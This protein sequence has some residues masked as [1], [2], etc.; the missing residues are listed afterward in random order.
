M[1][2]YKK[3]HTYFTIK[4]QCSPE[5]KKEEKY[6]LELKPFAV[7]PRVLFDKVKIGTSKTCTLFLF[8]PLLVQQLVCIEKFPFEKGFNIP[9]VKFCVPPLEEISINITWTPEKSINC[10]ENVLFKTSAGTR[11]QVFFLGTAHTPKKKKCWDKRA[12]QKSPRLH[13]NTSMNKNMPASFIF[14]EKKENLNLLDWKTEDLSVVNTPRFFPAKQSCLGQI[15]ELCDSPVRRQTYTINSMLRASQIG[16][17]IKNLP[18][19]L[20][21]N[22][23]KYD[24]IFKENI[25]ESR[26]TFV[27]SDLALHKELDSG[28][29]TLTE[30]EVKS[31]NRK[32]FSMADVKPTLLKK[33]SSDQFNQS[34]GYNKLTKHKLVFKENPESG[35][36]KTISISDIKS[37][38]QNELNADQ[39]NPSEM[40]QSPIQDENVFNEKLIKSNE[41]LKT[42]NF[43]EANPSLSRRLNIIQTERQQEIFNDSLE[44]TTSDYCA[45][46][47]H[48]LENCT[49]KSTALNFNMISY[50]CNVE[51][52]DKHNFPLSISYSN[53][54]SASV[55]QGRKRLNCTD[56][57][58]FT[59]FKRPCPPVAFEVSNADLP[60]PRET[61]FNLPHCLSNQNR[62]T[63]SKNVIK[64][65]KKRIRTLKLSEPIGTPKK[66]KEKIIQRNPYA[67]F[68][69]Y[70]DEYWK[71]KQESAFTNW[72]NFILT[73][74]DDF[75]S[76][77]VKVNSA[78]IWVESMKTA[79]PLRAPSKEELSFKTY[80][81]IKQLNQL[82]E[83]AYALYHSEKSSAVIK[84]VEKEVDMKKLM[85]RKDRALHADLGI[86]QDLL[87][88]LLSYN[89]LWL[90]IGLETIYGEIIPL[91]SNSDIIG[92]SRFIIHRF[93][94]NP[95][96]AAKYAYSSVIK[97]YKPG[98]EDCIKQFTLK[99][100][101]IIIYFLDVAKRARL[102]NHNPCLFCKSSKYKNSRSLLLTFSR[103][104]LFGEGDVTKHLRYLGYVVQHEQTSLEEFD[105][106]VR[107]IAV[108]LRCGLRLG[109]VVEILLQDWEI[110]KALRANTLNRLTKIHNNE[111]IMQALQRAS[112][113][114]EDNIDPRDIVDGNREKTLS[115]LWQIIFKTQIS[116][117]VNLELI[118]KENSYLR[119]SLKLKA[120]VATFNA[121]LQNLDKEAKSFQIGFLNSK[122]YKENEVIQQLLQWCQNVCAH[123]GIKV[124]NFTTSFSDGRALCCIVHHYHPNLLPQDKIKK[125]TS[126]YY[127]EKQ[128]N[129]DCPF[130]SDTEM[131]SEQTGKFVKNEKDNLDLAFQKFQEIGQIPIMSFPTHIQNNRIP[132]EKVVITL[133][134]Y[135]N[136][137]LMELSVEIRAARTILLAYRKWC[138]KKR[139]K[140]LAMQID[141]IV[142]IQRFWRSHLLHKKRKEENAAAICIQRFWKMI[143][144]KKE[145]ERLKFAKHLIY[146]NKQACVIQAAF[147]R[148]KA[149]KYQQRRQEAIVLLQSHVRKWLQRKEYLKLRSSAIKVQQRWRARRTIPSIQSE[150]RILHAKEIS[151][152]NSKCIQMLHYKEEI[153]YLKIVCCKN[154]ESCWKSYKTRKELD[155]KIR[156]AEVIQRYFH[157]W[158]EKKPH[159]DCA[160]NRQWYLK[161][162]ESTI[163]FQRQARI[164]LQRRTKSAI[165]IQSYVRMWLTRLK[166]IRIKA[167]IKIQTLWRGYKVRQSVT[168]KNII[169]SRQN[170]K[171]APSSEHKSLGNR[172][173]FA[174][175][176]LLKNQNLATILH[177]LQNL[178]VCTRLSPT[179]CERLKES[180]GISI[181]LQAIS[182]CNRSVPHQEIIKFSTD[183]LLNLA[184]YKK[185]VDCVWAE[186]AILTE[187]LRLMG[188][189]RDK[190]LPIFT[191]CCTLFW[192]FCQDPKKSQI[193]RENAFF[194]QQ[195]QH[196]YNLALRQK[197]NYS[198]TTAN[199]SAKHSRLKMHDTVNPRE[200]I[201]PDWVLAH[202]NKREFKDAFTAISSLIHSLGLRT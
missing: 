191:K 171:A 81:A 33:L 123:Y 25:K 49:E 136:I 119:R 36:C 151:C 47:I 44:S 80:T 146:L 125:E 101:L 139:Q 31:D 93:L 61:T 18:F 116:K 65:P 27:K 42:I 76:A 156:A 193:L 190:G 112:I 163:F 154:S 173:K 165:L 85:I 30:S 48:E 140:K 167:A 94:S 148:F 77:D 104:Y 39:F 169:K 184:K 41:N 150:E 168:D 200:S 115:L 11:A 45:E 73:P 8:N 202:F 141:A 32:T 155:R 142:K 69:S 170:I 96:I 1:E 74:N 66:I 5:N 111:V 92:L 145:L 68:N 2:S 130:P 108:D 159:I 23:I 144:A 53:N 183:I 89:P 106:A 57:D 172:T 72:L 189:Y 198:K 124:L 37:K 164:Y 22:H 138:L 166:Y 52:T 55:F 118:K 6:V 12:I 14:E 50:D 201:E 97:Y 182:V 98:Y 15:E 137:R 26:K 188:V 117:H 84:K 113:Q 29:F 56:L 157:L 134:S 178:E 127:F 58:S 132:D 105:Y 152:G 175:N 87:Q 122:L 16:T 186:E 20:P 177:A 102:I 180:G 161:L 91:Q 149:S 120:D 24:G 86:K 51:A 71:E 78:E 107:N 3:K 174:L 95:D 195:I 192:I 63:K 199:L 59:V 197:K 187:G 135:V 19:C 54:E 88:M 17:D 153:F 46:N 38:C 99:K 133:V 4:A 110:F 70:Y 13:K 9:E 162:K 28:L 143:S 129:E 34:Q 181:I 128:E 64:I 83:A 103:E 67:S 100:F 126:C 194:V 179:C 114:I 158:R 7:A 176:L 121:V 185:T 79:A 10:R 21:T 160:G 62:V 109:R 82:R 35:N 43:L 196:F 60:K 90:R 131:S 75:K 40:S 147:R